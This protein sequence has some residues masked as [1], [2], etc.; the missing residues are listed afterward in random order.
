LLVQDGRK[1]RLVGIGEDGSGLYRHRQFGRDD[2]WIR[3]P[4]GSEKPWNYLTRFGRKRP[5]APLA[6]GR[7]RRP[8][9]SAATKTSR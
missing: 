4:D 6:G 3:F 8:R 5:L 7:W 1:Y 9:R 2:F